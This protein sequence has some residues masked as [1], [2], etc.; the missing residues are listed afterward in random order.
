MGLANTDVELFSFR[1][2]ARNANAELDITDL[3][4]R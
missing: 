4:N 3:G 1:H 2:C